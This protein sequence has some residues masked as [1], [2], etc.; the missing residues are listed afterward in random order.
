MKSIS[1]VWIGRVSVAAALLGLQLASAAP[2][3]PV[4]PLQ[5]PMAQTAPKQLELH[6]HVRADPY[7][8][9]KERDNPQVRAYLEAENA[10]TAA[11]MAHTDA[12]Q[13]KLYKEIVGRIVKDDESVP[14]RLDDYFYYERFRGEGDYPVHCRRKGSM[15]APEEVM[16]DVNELARGH[17][18]FSARGLNVS[19]GQDILAFATDPVGRRFYT[20]RF[21]NLATG[22]LLEVARRT[23]GSWRRLSRP[24]GWRT[25]RRSFLTA[26]TSCSKVS[27]SSRITW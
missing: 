3:T 19:S 22:Q 18:F 8:W 13:E 21:K 6:G 26:T 17:E 4:E 24:P 1:F 12:L 9:L 14:Y 15:E 27:R 25:G 16:L 23:S 20:L 10:Y 11:V 7:H 2:Q 5:P